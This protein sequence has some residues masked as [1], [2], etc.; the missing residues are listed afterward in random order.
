MTRALLARRSNRRAANR[1]DVSIPDRGLR[2]SIAAALL[3]LAMLGTLLPERAVAQASSPTWR[4]TVTP[5]GWMSGVGG[6]VGIRN[7]VTDV[8]LGFND[9]LDHLRFAAMAALGARKGPWVLDADV[10]YVSLGASRAVAVRGASGDVTLDQ[11]EAI[12]RGAAGYTPID[13]RIWTVDVLAGARYWNLSTNIGIDPANRNSRTRSGSVGWL[14]A[15]GGARVR[16]NPASDFHLVADADA[17]GGASRNTW[18]A[19]GTATFD[20]SRRYGLMAGYEYLSVDYDHDGFRFDTH[21]N[22]F[23]AGVTFTF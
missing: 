14:D 17:G 21:T 4:F 11:R 10:V 1:D 20:L 6:R 16:F 5:Y 8:D 9:V 23:L 19:T 18:R 15:I 22:G 7:L 2:T 13:T 12:I 3:T